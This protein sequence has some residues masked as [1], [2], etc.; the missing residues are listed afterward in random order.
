L[1]F[2]VNFNECEMIELFL[3]N[4]GNWYLLGMLKPFFLTKL[5][6]VLWKLVIYV[7]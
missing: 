5:V 2:D 4:I 6:T 3:I 1:T 7:H